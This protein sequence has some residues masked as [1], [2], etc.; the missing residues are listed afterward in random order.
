MVAFFLLWNRHEADK[1]VRDEFDPRAISELMQ[2]D[3][4]GFA[5]IKTQT[6]LDSWIEA[7]ESEVEKTSRATVKKGQRKGIV[8]TG[9]EIQ[10]ELALVYIH[11]F[12]ASRLEADPVITRV[13]AKLHAN[14]YF[15]RLKAHGL[16]DG[17]EFQTV[18]ARDWAF[19]VEEAIAIGKKIGKRVVIVAMSTGAPLV[20]ENVLRHRFGR[21]GMALIVPTNPLGDVAALIL[22]SPNYEVKAFGSSLLEGPFAS[23]FAALAIGTHREFQTSSTMHAERWTSRYRVNGLIEMLKAVA[24]VR[25]ADFGEVGVPVLTV[26]S[27]RDDVVDTRE[28]ERRSK[29]F[30]NPKSEIVEWEPATRHELASATFNPEQVP[31]FVDLLKNWISSA[32]PFEATRD[33]AAGNRE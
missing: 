9:S 19:D 26:Y 22:L 32:V 25:D 30:T 33:R 1:I 28:I 23:E 13:A 15:T 14:V 20:L 18:R 24:S 6:A 7:R 16:Q 12:S 17:E 3:F 11:G 4:E 10:T 8:W 21:E 27:R 2:N 31:A 5:E 29:E